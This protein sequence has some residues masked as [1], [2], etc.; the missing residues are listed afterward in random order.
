MFLLKLSPEAT[1]MKAKPVAYTLPES[2]LPTKAQGTLGKWRMFL[3]F[4]GQGYAQF[5]GAL[6]T[7]PS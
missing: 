2:L 3:Q 1:E 5:S 7:V 4:P 6:A